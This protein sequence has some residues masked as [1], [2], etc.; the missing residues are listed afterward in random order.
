[1]NNKRTR[2]YLLP[3]TVAIL[4]GV[5]GP[6]SAPAHIVAM[7]SSAASGAAAVASPVKQAENQLR[8]MGESIHRL[9]SAA[10]DLVRECNRENTMMAGGEIDFIGTDVIPI[11]P[12]TAEGL[13]GP[14]YMPPRKKYIDLHMAQLAQLLPIL[15]QE[16]QSTASPDPAQASQ[17]TQSIAE[18]NNVYADAMLHFN[19]LK[20]STVI[21]PYDATAITT[22]ATALHK[23]IAE[24]DKMRKSVY[25]AIKRDPND[26]AIDS[27]ATGSS[28]ATK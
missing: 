10:T 7:P 16:I 23:D 19:N 26:K 4:A 25:T 9:K 28:P 3:L 27:A 22:E 5:A 20:G 15:Q 14:V 24:I 11:L 6:T 2:Q 13:G 12:D 17:T 1:M 21:Q 8:E 18:M